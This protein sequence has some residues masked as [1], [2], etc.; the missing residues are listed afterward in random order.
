MQA[1]NSQIVVVKS[2]F[3]D[4]KEGLSLTEMWRQLR[5]CKSESDLFDLVEESYT[6]GKFSDEQEELRSSRQSPRTSQASDAEVESEVSTAPESP[7][8]QPV[9]P[10][11]KEEQKTSATGRSTMMMR[12]VPNNYTREMLLSMLNN[13]GFSGKYDF[14]YLPHDFDR[15]ANLGYAFVNLVSD[16]A[17]HAFWR[18]FDGFK[19]WTLPSAKVCRVSWS[20][21]HQG[22]A[23]HVE[24][25]RNSPVMHRSVPDEY[26]PVVF[27]DGVRQPFPCPTRKIKPPPPRP[28]Q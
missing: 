21:P 26:R 19:R 4:L 3:V 7:K 2:T 11:K 6:P 1:A 15:S 5:Q 28:S 20:G 16:E 9:R 22:L 14:V 13:Y 10:Y 18:K 17:V 12:N 27:T 24:R 8:Q 23:A 25:Y